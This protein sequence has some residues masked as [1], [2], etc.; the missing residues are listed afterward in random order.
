MKSCILR[1]M[2]IGM[3]LIV[4]TFLHSRLIDVEGGSFV[5]SAEPLTT[6]QLSSFQIW[7]TEVTRYQYN[8]V[9]GIPSDNLANG[10]LPVHSISWYDAIVF[11]NRKSIREGLTPV[12]RYAGYRTNPDTWPE[13][14]DTNDRNHFNIICDWTADGYRLPTEMEWMYAA[15]GGNQLENYQ[16]SG[17]D[18]INAVAWFGGN[19]HQRLR[20]VGLKQS[21]ALDLFDMSG[22]VWEW[23]WDIFGRYEHGDQ[24]NPRG[25]GRGSFRV[26]RGGAWISTSVTCTVSHRFSFAPTTKKDY[27]G[28]RVV[29]NMTRN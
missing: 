19:S 15:K 20:E 4:G 10:N 12:Y 14:W 11:C 26:L 13:G 1:V 29:R 3:F 21:N 25:P 7:Q 6:V 2:S 16:Y 24:V 27:I 8:E 18:D 22:N 17:S 23:C 28:F 9:M 5:R